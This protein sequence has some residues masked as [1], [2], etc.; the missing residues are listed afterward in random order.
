MNYEDYLQTEHWQTVRY[1]ALERAEH[2]CM[3]CCDRYSNLEVHHNN[4]NRVGCEMPS[5]VIVLCDSCH[6]KFHDVME[7]A[8]TMIDDFSQINATEHLQ[9]MILLC[10]V[11]NPDYLGWARVKYRY[12]SCPEY[13]DLYERL[14]EQM[15]L[16]A[17]GMG[18]DE[19]L[20]EL[21]EHYLTKAGFKVENL[22]SI[23]VINE[24]RKVP[25]KDSIFDGAVKKLRHLGKRKDQKKLL[26]AS[27]GEIGSVELAKRL[28]ELR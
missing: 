18:S 12:F 15:D 7:N 27:S 17:K 24:F 8:P 19:W 4:Y 3:V 26:L 9:S 22:L 6:E 1:D 28:M 21:R 11:T 25:D 20:S 16:N 14:N 10:I 23:K 2:H 5:D 13:R